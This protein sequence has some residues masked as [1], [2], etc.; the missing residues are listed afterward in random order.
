MPAIPEAPTAS[1]GASLPGSRRRS[2]SSGQRKAVATM[3][4]GK[5]VV[6]AIQSAKPAARP[7]EQRGMKS[8]PPALLAQRVDR[9]RRRG[10]APGPR[11]R[12]AG[13]RPGRFRRS[14]SPARPAPGTRAAAGRPRHCARRA[15]AESASA[16]GSTASSCSGRDLTRGLIA[17]CCRCRRSWTPAVWSGAAGGALSQ[18]SVVPS[19]SLPIWVMR[20]ISDGSC[21]R[22]SRVKA[23]RSPG[24]SPASEA[25]GRSFA[26]ANG[27]V[28]ASMLTTF[29]AS[30]RNSGTASWR[31]TIS[32]PPG[33]GS[34]TISP[35]I[36]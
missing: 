15:S 23:I 9:C 10:P 36:A 21:Q 26:S 4:I 6:S 32:R 18:E 11:R 19:G 29:P 30:S 3:T 12:P 1:N 5:T 34:R 25:A 33:S 31:M 13:D 2:R 22:I 35:R 27:M 24:A 8:L 28:I 7:I 17:A 16:R 14:S 20:A